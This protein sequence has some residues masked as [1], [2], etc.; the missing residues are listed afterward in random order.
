[1]EINIDKYNEVSWDYA[2]Q[3]KI[4]WSIPI[5][6]HEIKNA[7]KGNIRLK[8]A[9]HKIVPS[10]WIKNVKGKKILCLASTGGQQ[11]PLLAAAGGNVT[12]FDISNKQLAQDITVARKENLDICIMQGSLTDLSCFDSSVFDIIIHPVSNNFIENIQYVWNE[13][14]RILRPKGM[15]LS[16]FAN[17]IVFLFDHDL[18]DQGILQMKYKVPYSDLYQLPKKRLERKIKLKKPLC[19][20]HSLENQ[21]GGQL[22]A[23]FLISDFLE[24]YNK[25][26][27]LLANYC[28]GYIMTKAIK[29]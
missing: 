12:V 28:P 1:L 9:N 10:S 3:Q 11:A 15:L 19:F 6:S 24:D 14:F 18:E 29:K 8:L 5:S 25:D 7:R 2:V 21:I 20:G 17:P 23:G 16:G 27:D 26:G 4:Q 22:K 13:C